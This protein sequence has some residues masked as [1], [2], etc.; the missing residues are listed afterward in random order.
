MHSLQRDN[1][2]CLDDEGLQTLLCERPIT[3]VSE[4]HTDPEPLA[5]NH[6]LLL[7]SEEKP[8]YDNFDR[9]DTYAR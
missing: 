2:F 4:D 5:P 1:T 8:S 6:L 7:C 3:Q 9:L